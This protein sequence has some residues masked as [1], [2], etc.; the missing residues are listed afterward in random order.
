LHDIGYVRGILSG[1]T[2][3][4]FVIDKD[5]TKITP[6]VASD[7]ALTPYHV[8]R[9]KMFAIERLGSSGRRN[10]RCRCDR[11]DPFSRKNRSD[12]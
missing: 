3:T 4:E 10:A 12:R 11:T 1:D 5:Y 9:S 7:A 2:E 8:D 6:L